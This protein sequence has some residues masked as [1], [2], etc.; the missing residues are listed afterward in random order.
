MPKLLEDF[1]QNNKPQIILTESQR[2]RFL[3]ELQQYGDLDSFCYAKQAISKNGMYVTVLN[4]PIADYLK[5]YAPEYAFEFTSPLQIPYI[6]WRSVYEQL[7]NDE[8]L[9]NQ[10][11][12]SAFSITENSKP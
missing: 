5:Q 8:N 9:W 6:F 11:D 3:E 12:S 10:M 4:M 1:F 7:Q 2:K